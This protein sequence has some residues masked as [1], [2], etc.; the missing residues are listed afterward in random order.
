MK[1]KLLISIVFLIV[2]FESKSQTNLYQ[3]VDP[4]I[5][6][7]FSNLDHVSSG[8]TYVGATYPFG[9]VQFTPTFFSP[10][11]GFVIN[12]LS[13]A[14]CSHLGNFPVLPI[15]GELISSPIDMKGYPKYTSLKECEA[16]YFSVEMADKVICNATV[17]KRT[18][19]AQ[20]L[21]PKNQQKGTIIIGSGIKDTEELY[22][23]HV[24][25]ASA[26]SCEGFAEGGQFCGHYADTK[27]RIYFAAEFNR[28]ASKYG[29]WK[30]KN[31][32][33]QLTASGIN[34]GAYFTFDTNENN[35]VEYKISISYVSVANARE[36][37]Q[38]DNNK[39]D[40]SVLKEATQSEWNKRLGSIEISLENPDRT[41]QFYTHFYH[42]LIHPNIFNDVNGEYIG[43]D[44]NVHKVESGRD[45]YTSF[46]GWDT[47]RTQSQLLAM[48]FPKEASDMMQSEVDFAKQA[49]GFGRWILANIETG[50]MWGDPMP[51]II[52]N[53]WAFGAKD[54]DVKTAFKYMKSGAT[55]PGQY[56]Q[57]QLCRP[58]L[59][60]YLQKGYTD[61]PAITLEYTSSDFAI[62]QFA[63]QAIGDKKE[64]A[65]F[66]NHSQKWKTLYDPST[67]WLRARSVKDGSWG[68]PTY[69]W[70]EATKTKHFW[71]VPFNLKSLIDTIGGVEY[72]AKRLDTLF[73]RLDASYGEDWYAAGN[74]PGF[75][76][77]WTYNWIGKPYKTTE[78]MDR[79]FTEIYNSAA[80][81]LPG[82][83]DLGAMG[84]F[85]VFGSIGLFP[86]IPGVGG[87]AVNKPQFK[88]ITI[89]FPKGNLKIDGGYTSLSINSM[90][91]NGKNYK[92]SWL[93]W[94]ELENGGKIEYELTKN[95]KP[96]WATDEIL[97]SYNEL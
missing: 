84:S 26:N 3:L 74:E 44:Y 9:M 91:L 78:V 38:K 2:V 63:L 51:I 11:L 5:G 31:I 77:P 23:A 53:S 66:V 94:S 57:N 62:G 87:F 8:F 24:T 71:M 41:K 60:T 29:V 61:W 36:N 25:V 83:D 82:N 7:E 56:S 73:V 30:D 86:M 81:G 34:S 68:D 42:A 47:Y 49:G 33:S 45:Y 35:E 59:D 37:L 46:S 48:L 12:Q 54:F 39:G 22:N 58:E 75:Q 18:G 32:L 52:A 93:K 55:V 67:K 1:K 96:K 16:G 50:I 17:S 72:A 79:V 40:F 10:N 64:A 21:F 6:T 15:A 4:R 70:G 19:I 85:Y 14:G 80:A 89:H 97:P 43:A 76:A 65:F 90:K 69:G 13:G 88:N 27:Y 20:F 95:T 92:S 28:N